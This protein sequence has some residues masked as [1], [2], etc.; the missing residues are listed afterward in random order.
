MLFYFFQTL[1]VARQVLSKR[2]AMKLALIMFH[3]CY[4]VWCFPFSFK[5]NL[6][7]FLTSKLFFQNSYCCSHAFIS[8]FWFVLFRTI[9]LH[10]LRHHFEQTCAVQS[11]HSIKNFCK[12]INSNINLKISSIN[13]KTLQINRA[14]IKP[15]VRKPMK[16]Q[17][18]IYWFLLDVFKTRRK[19]IKTGR[20]GQSS[21]NR[22][23]PSETRRVDRSE[24]A[25]LLYNLLH[26]GD[27]F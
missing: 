22:E 1:V 5:W 4:R 27:L 13:Q 24:I 19:I 17:Q 15:D 7:Y 2:E 23:S 20:L 26:N 14:K 3:I 21:Q 6:V 25:F 8:I 9:I 10:S 18:E 12:C 16:W 11:K